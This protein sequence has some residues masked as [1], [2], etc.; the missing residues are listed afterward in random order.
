MARQLLTLLL[1]IACAGTSIEA[2]PLLSEVLAGSSDLG[3]SATT[4]LPE[5]AT[6]DIAFDFTVSAAD[7]QAVS[8]T[9]VTQ[10]MQY[11]V[12]TYGADQVGSD[13]SSVP[14]PYVDPGHYALEILRE[15]D[16]DGVQWRLGYY[17]KAGDAETRLAVVQ[18][19]T[20]VD[21]ALRVA[22]SAGG[23][24]MHTTVSGTPVC[25]DLASGGYDVSILSYVEV[26]INSL[27]AQ[28]DEMK[29]NHTARIAAINS[30]L[31]KHESAT[32]AASGY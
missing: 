23:C 16:A 17:T 8:Q 20:V 2:S 9:Q 25:M 13:A 19:G 30:T 24:P 7:G 28:I 31:N 18:S 32:K 10:T 26:R 1:M 11:L 21:G 15:P 4:F 27:T 6:F 22:T 5:N 3:Y 12:A 29:A 14:L